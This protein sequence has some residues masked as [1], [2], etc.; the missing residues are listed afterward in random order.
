MSQ[1]LTLRALTP[2][3]GLD[4][5]DSSTL[6]ELL[7]PTIRADFIKEYK[8][9]H[10]G[11]KPSDA[12]IGQAIQ[13]R[14]PEYIDRF[15]TSLGEDS[16]L[17]HQFFQWHMKRLAIIGLREALPLDSLPSLAAGLQN[18]SYKD[19]MNLRPF[20][21]AQRILQSLGF[22]E[23]PPDTT[24]PSQ[25]QL[26]AKEMTTLLFNGLVNSARKKQGLPPIHETTS[27]MDL[28]KEKALSGYRPNATTVR[29]DITQFLTEHGYQPTPEA[30]EKVAGNILFDGQQKGMPMDTVRLFVTMKILD[31]ME[32]N[33]PKQAAIFAALREKA[34]R[35]PLAFA[36]RDLSD[37]IAEHKVGKEPA[38]IIGNKIKADMSQR[39]AHINKA[40]DYPEPQNDKE[41][42][43]TYSQYRSL[44][45]ARPDRE[46]DVMMKIAILQRRKQLSPAD[47]KKL[48]DADILIQNPHISVQE[49]L[50]IGLIV[51]GL[52]VHDL[53]RF[54][55]ARSK[56][57]RAIMAR[58]GVDLRE[59]ILPLVMPNFDREM[60]ANLKRNGQPHE[61]AQWPESAKKERANI[62]ALANR[63]A[64]NDKAWQDLLK[65]SVD[66]KAIVKE[67]ANK[68]IIAGLKAAF[69]EQGL[70]VN[71]A[72][73][74][75]TNE[76]TPDAPA[77]AVIPP[78]KTPRL[79]KHSQPV[80]PRLP[81]KKVVAAAHDLKKAA[82]G[83]RKT[84][85]PY[86]P[87]ATQ[88]VMHGGQ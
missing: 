84:A 85:S 46:D 8:T 60:A 32:E 69:G 19:L 16:T 48:S 14:T 45:K 22:K 4:K 83:G 30:I 59:K 62:A 61:Q 80:I 29:H 65:Y 39:I 77:P 73:K 70:P 66:Q 47:N 86:P 55:A 20:V 31:L 21:T 37:A 56:E 6:P 63:A 10:K 18:M 53:T 78:P 79:P 36:D 1:T 13:Q 52:P 81:A 75:A 42:E 35:D 3:Y 44:L 33:L 71:I 76:L 64:K 49:A 9:Q 12:A 11:I 28:V 88:L 2:V 17:T 5:P 57:G 7:A 50:T 58:G 15:F 40:V 34:E 87:W 72:A 27:I 51:K 41:R 74:A 38:L 24:N 23:N 26:S 67:V 82:S 68:E 54:F 43:R 25:G